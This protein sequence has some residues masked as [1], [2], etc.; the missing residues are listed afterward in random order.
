MQVQTFADGNDTVWRERGEIVV[1][2]HNIDA[3]SGGSC[4]L[5]SAFVRS[6]NGQFVGIADFPIE[7]YVGLD[8][9]TERWLDYESVIMV[10][11]NNVIKN[12]RIGSVI[13]ICS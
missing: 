1:G 12:M 10:A 9:S 2:V 4:K 7:D 13:N 6:N 11:I 5:G 3:K 8:E